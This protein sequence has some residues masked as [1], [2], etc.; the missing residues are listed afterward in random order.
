MQTAKTLIRFVSVAFPGRTQW[1]PRLICVFAILLVLS[2]TLYYKVCT[3]AVTSGH[4]VT[5]SWILS[6]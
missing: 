6:V 4:I 3:A 1:M 2:F 5:P